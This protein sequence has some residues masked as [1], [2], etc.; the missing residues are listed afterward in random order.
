MRLCY[1]KD[2]FQLTELGNTFQSWGREVQKQFFEYALE[3]VRQ[4][5]YFLPYKLKNKKIIGVGIHLSSSLRNIKEW[6]EEEIW[7]N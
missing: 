7:L 1:K 3:Q 4:K 5:E 2:L 6:E